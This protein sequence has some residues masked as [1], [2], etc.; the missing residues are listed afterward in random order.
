MTS[1]L[2]S[3]VKLAVASTF[4]EQRRVD[5][6][7]AIIV[8]YG[9]VEDMNDVIDAEKIL[10][11]ISCD[12]LALSCVRL[13]HLKPASDPILAKPR[14]LKVSCLVLQIALV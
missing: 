13:G 10:S 4:K 2:S 7:K 14:P 12:L 6:D 3:I 5:R 9:L 8:M 11:A 1:N